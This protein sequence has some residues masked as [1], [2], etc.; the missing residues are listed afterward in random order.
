[1][2]GRL[3]KI[4]RAALL[5]TR[6]GMMPFGVGLGAALIVVLG[7]FLRDLVH[8]FL[9]IRG[10][11]RAEVMVEVLKL[12]DLVLVANLLVM[13]IGAGVAMYL[14]ASLGDETPSAWGDIDVASLKLKLFASISAI[15]AIDLLESFVNI[16]ATDKGD[17]MW[18][19]AIL[20]TFVAAGVMLAVMDRL[21]DRH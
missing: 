15:A 4:F 8:I 6:W 20:L 2:D 21:A 12:V 5:G 11:G 3:N 19:I 16:G 9:D 14:P 1:M 10:I 7:Q 18:E 17:V 13:L